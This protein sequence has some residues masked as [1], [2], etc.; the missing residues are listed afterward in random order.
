LGV[1]VALVGIVVVLA[2]VIARAI[3]LARFSDPED[4][5]AAGAVWSAF[6][7]DLRT[8]GWVLAGSG[9]VVAAAA[10]SR[11]RPLELEGRF[12]QA[13][14]LVVTEPQRTGWRIVRA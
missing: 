4:R 3:V 13:F 11:L 7:A 1:G 10:T 14:S 2:Y 5:A 12:K 9:A 8:L 6:L